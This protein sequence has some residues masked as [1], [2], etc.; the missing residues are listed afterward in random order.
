VQAHIDV[1]V[2]KLAR[3]LDVESDGVDLLTKGIKALVDEVGMDTLR[4][5]ESKGRIGA[6]LDGGNARK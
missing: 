4:G 3:V 2:E 1:V 6:F 5:S